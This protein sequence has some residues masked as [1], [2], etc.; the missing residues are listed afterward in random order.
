MPAS[1]SGLVFILWLMSLAPKTAEDSALYPALLAVAGIAIYVTFFVRQIRGVY[2]ARYPT[3]R[4]AEALVLTAAMFL[5]IFSMVYVTIS[6]RDP[7]SFTEPL[8]SFSAYYYALT[9][10]ATVGFGDIAPTNV[11]ARSVTMVQMALDIAFIAVLIRVMGGAA[12]KALQLRARV[13]ARAAGRGRRSG[14][15]GYEQARDQALADPSAFWLAAAGRIDWIDAPTV[16]L[17]DSAAPLYRWFPDGMLNTCANA[18]D[19]H[20]AAGRGDVAAIR[21]DSPV[22]G[23]KATIT[24][25]ALLELVSHFGGS[26]GRSR[27]RSRRSGARV[28]ADDPRGGRGHARVRAAGGRPLRRVRRVRAGR[29]RGP[30]RRRGADGDRLGQLRHRAVA[31]RR[32]QAAARRGPAA[33]PPCARRIGRPPA[34]RDASRDGG[35]R[36][37]LA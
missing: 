4:A 32:L 31:R 7:S 26:A 20:V 23:T 14:V 22:T 29:A 3:L 17:D 5:A 2:K 37:R 9:V 36:R 25:A 10:L 11:P 8:D 19:R 35:A 28:H 30:H 13:A 33:G 21:Y 18:V 16:G 27:R 24:Y 12:K 6:L 34:T 15:T 1:W